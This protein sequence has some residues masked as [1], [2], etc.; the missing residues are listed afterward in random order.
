ML[1]CSVDKVDELIEAD[2][3][4]LVRVHLIE[5]DAR[6]PIRQVWPALQQDFP[7]LREPE[8]P[9]A[10]LIKLLELPPQLPR[11]GSGGPRGHPGG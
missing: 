6:L 5:E 8:R 4:R 10:V 7:E 3:S 9:V 1:L 2:P 11:L